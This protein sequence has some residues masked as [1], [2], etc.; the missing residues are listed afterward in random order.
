[1]EIQD[2][3]LVLFTAI[4]FSVFSLEVEADSCGPIGYKAAE[5]LGPEYWFFDM[6]SSEC[7]KMPQ[8]KDLEILLPANETSHA[9][10]FYMHICRS[11]EYQCAGTAC[12]RYLFTD[13]Y[14]ALLGYEIDNPFSEGIRHFGSVFVGERNLCEKSSRPVQTS[15]NFFCDP[16]TKWNTSIV[17]NHGGAMSPKPVSWTFDKNSCALTMNFNYSGAC[18]RTTYQ[19]S[20]GRSI[21]IGSI[22]LI[23]FFPGLA[24]Y[25][26][27]GILVKSFAGHRGKDMI[28]HGSFWL[29]LPDLIMDGFVFTMATITCQKQ[30]NRTSYET[31]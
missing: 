2:G 20:P 26:L 7:K 16:S 12:L 24:L 31:M 17:H 10:R 28:P 21:S 3:G 1:M 30:E 6:S 4:A 23:L 27:I 18:E 8:P 22:L 11:M 9:C 5:L 29:V 25:F 19:S 14:I 13:D 15:L